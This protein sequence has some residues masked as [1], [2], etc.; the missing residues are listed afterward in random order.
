MLM[1][2]PQV[3]MAPPM[4]VEAVRG[5]DMLC[6]CA[7]I[8]AGALACATSDKNGPGRGPVIRLGRK[9]RR[10]SAAGS[11]PEPVEPSDVPPHSVVGSYPT[12]TSVFMTIL[13]VLAGLMGAAGIVLTA[14]SAHAARA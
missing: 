10:T 12:A 1:H 5:V 7:G 8:S 3:P 14:I 9:K 13:I 11:I 6:D 4:H 2:M